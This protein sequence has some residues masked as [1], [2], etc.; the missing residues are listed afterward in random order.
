MYE[1][2]SQSN[3]SQFWLNVVIMIL[4]AGLFVAGL[5]YYQ[6]KQLTQLEE[7]VKGLQSQLASLNT[8]T[9]FNAKNTANL[10]AKVDQ[11]EIIT[12]GTRELPKVALTFDTDMTSS[13]KDKGAQWYDPEIIELLN[14]KQVPA[15]F[16]LTGMWAETYP[17]AAKQIANN[18]LF[19]VESHS[20]Q[21]KAF[22][23]PCHG[24]SVLKNK[25]EKKVAIEKAQQAIKEA[26]GVTPS[27]FRFP[28]GCYEQQDLELVN[29]AGLK[30]VQWDVVSEDAFAESANPII[31][32]TL[33]Q[34]QNGS[35]VI[36]HLGGPNAPHTTQAL[37]EII[38]RLRKEGYQFTTIH[39]LLNPPS[40]SSGS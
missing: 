31:D 6:Q 22:S 39:P 13:M 11:E 5:Y 8:E 34:T 18:N 36:F 14:E 16:F 21:S 38:P 23:Q 28:G 1:V 3:Q 4:I 33:Q 15:T 27:Y 32:K 2:N 24:L 20:Y 17:E 7:E 9:E 37:K 35:I 29:Q 19:Q 30:A 12:S 25:E 26:T 10:P 40:V